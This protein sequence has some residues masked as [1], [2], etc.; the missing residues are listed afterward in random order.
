VS[1]ADEGSGRVIARSPAAT[2]LLPRFLEH[3]RRDVVT[4][5]AALADGD[6]ETIRRLGHN[7]AGNGTSYG[8]P[9]MS[10][11][12][13]HLEAEAGAGNSA[14]VRGQL[15]SLEACLERVADEAKAGEG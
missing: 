13:R 9:A 14:A 12:G 1:A 3:R 11:I 10:T 15:A 8:F 6:F 4:L 5:R 7:M 2:A